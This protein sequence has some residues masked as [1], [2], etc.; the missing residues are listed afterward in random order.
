MADHLE[1]IG[2]IMGDYRLLRWLGGG[3]F[4]NVYLAEQMRDGRQVAIKVLQIH[5]TRQDDLR[6]FINEARTMRLRHPHIVPLLDF[7]L[8][9]ENMPFLVMEYAPNGTLRDRYPKGRR[10]PLLT[11]VEYT[12]HVASALQYAH[13]HQLV[14]RDVKPENMLMRS[15]GVV[16]LSDFGIATTAPSTYSLSANQGMA[17][18][19]SYM[20]PEQ[21]AGKPRA[22]SDQYALAVVIYEWLSGRCPFQGTAIE[23]AMQHATQ[24]PPSLVAQVPE[25]PQVVE[26][27]LFKALA[28]DHKERFPSMQAFIAALQH[29]SYPATFR[30]STSLGTIRELG[31]ASY[32]FAQP[33]EPFPQMEA[34]SSV[35]QGTAKQAAKSGF[36]TVL[37]QEMKRSVSVDPVQEPR[38]EA[39]TKVRVLPPARKRGLSKRVAALLLVLVALVIVGGTYAY[40]TVKSYSAQLQ[41]T[42]IN[43]AVATTKAVPTA[44]YVATAKAATNAYANAVALHG[45]MRGFDAQHTGNNP[46][47]QILNST[48][49]SQLQRKWAVPTGGVIYSDPAV[50]NGLVYVG[51]MDDKLYAFDATTGQQKWA[52]PTGGSISTSPAVVDGVVYINSG[53]DKL[54]AFDAMTGQ[55]KWFVTTSASLAPYPSS[56][57][58]VVNRVVY[59]GSR[60]GKIYAFDAMT[61]QQKWVVATGGRTSSV[62]VA[63]GEVY[64]GSD[65]Y[66]LYAFDATTGQQKWFV[67]IGSQISF[68]TAVVNGVVY[69]GSL[70]G[71][72]YA[73]DA[74]SGQQKWV[75]STGSYIIGDPAVAGG[76]VY[77]GSED[78]KLYAFDAVSGQQKWVSPPT[79]NFISSSPIV[80][81]GLVYTHSND[82]KLYVFD[83]VSGQQKWAS[84]DLTLSSSAA[85]A[86]GMVYVS[87]DDH[88]L[89]AFSLP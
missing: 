76:E 41:A 68:L 73:F 23:V 74:I 71:K 17:G 3:A 55:Q 67:V 21:L 61:G 6:A 16:L 5:L 83:A 80:A 30:Q 79:G 59:I 84:P 44:A 20:A 56:S 1:R 32:A 88:N 63:D 27:V 65:D 72:V 22:A 85:V 81:N 70:A 25:V 78:N 47:E 35:P 69:I 62:T 48:N 24:L 42:A 36:E 13:D 15:D 31:E 57:P 52:A 37:S 26:A 46:Y 8:S 38:G 64:V 77:I 12:S 50:A 11:A 40:S 9:D 51:S 10:V 53:D 29:A 18:T 49:I 14:H 2:Q 34:P 58:T 43:D 28:K 86:N 60:G 87:S 45:V 33:I 54:Y 19:V 82:G 66:K 4:G 75:A 7:G 39:P 89:Y